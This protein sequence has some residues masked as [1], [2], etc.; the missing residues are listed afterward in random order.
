MRILILFLALS[1]SFM[2]CSPGKD[3]LTPAEK[4]A[5]REKIIKVI[6]DNIKAS[7]EQDFASMV[8][9]LADE[10][11]FYGTDSSE[12]IK[13]FPEYKKA[14]EKQWEEYDQM[15]YGDMFDIYLEIDEQGRTAFIIYGIPLDILKDGKKA[16]L[17]LRVARFLVKIDKKWVIRSGIVGVVSD[18]INYE[19][20]EP[21]TDTT[22][23]KEE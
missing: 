22:T 9:T 8:R 13:T 2:A 21:E 14:I 23:T 18:G 11:T 3:Y 17:Y 10:V 19:D 1:I 12:I 6:E 7:E 20:I 15:D 4:E 5:E 16:H